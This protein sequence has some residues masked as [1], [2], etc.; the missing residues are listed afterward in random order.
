MSIYG[1]FRSESVF[2]LALFAIV[3]QVLLGIRPNS[4]IKGLFQF[5]TTWVLFSNFFIGSDKII[6]IKIS[7]IGEQRNKTYGS[8]K[9]ENTSSV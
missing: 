6:L 2:A 4:F 8:M 1:K 5:V 3:T 9:G 7:Q